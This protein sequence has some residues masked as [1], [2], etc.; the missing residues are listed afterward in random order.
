MKIN[1]AGLYIIKK[2]EGFSSSVYVCPSGRATIGYGST[3]DDSGDPVTLDHADI[4]VDEAEGLL[5]QEVAHVEKAIG[6]LTKASL[7]DNMFSALASL[8]YN[9][10][11]GA[12]Q[13]STLRMKL[14]REDYA[15]AC[16]EFPKWRRGGGKILPGL[17]RRREEEAALFL[18]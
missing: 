16:G 4:T 14:N 7:T 1:D 15:G 5:R 18:L 17:V 8:V 2:Y 11:S 12:Y 6:R 13:R 3:W 9:I 10:G